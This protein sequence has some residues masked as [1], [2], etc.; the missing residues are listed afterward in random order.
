MQKP[1]WTLV[2]A[3]VN[4]YWP[5]KPWSDEQIANWF[6]DLK[7]FEFVAVMKAVIDYARAPA[8][9][10][11]PHLGDIYTPCHLSRALA[12]SWEERKQLDSPDTPLLEEPTEDGDFEPAVEDEA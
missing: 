9:P 3:K 2:A 7:E 8:H 4:D 12:F 5:D 10:W 1:E 6:E 11:P